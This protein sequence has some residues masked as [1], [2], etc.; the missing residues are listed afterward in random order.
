[1]DENYPWKEVVLVGTGG[2]F[3]FPLNAVRF[4]CAVLLDGDGDGDEPCMVWVGN[5]LDR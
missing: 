4:I 2:S 3:S 1:M 5:Y